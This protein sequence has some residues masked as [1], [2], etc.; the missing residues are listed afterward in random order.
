M[1]LDSDHP[2]T[3][4]WVAEFVSGPDDGRCYTFYTARLGNVGAGVS[5][6]LTRSADRRRDVSTLVSLITIGV[7]DCSELADGLVGLVREQV[8]CLSVVRESAA[9]SWRDLPDD[10]NENAMLHHAVGMVRGAGA[11]A[12]CWE[13]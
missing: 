1:E 7:S 2:V 8:G 10:P 4:R 5:Y 3:A 13:P 9:A 11:V 12:A 6:L